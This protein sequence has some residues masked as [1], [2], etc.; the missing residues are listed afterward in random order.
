VQVP[1]AGGEWGEVTLASVGNPAVSKAL[2]ALNELNRR[3][4]SVG[5]RASFACFTRLSGAAGFTAHF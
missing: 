1:R 2:N 5:R 4:A 3:A